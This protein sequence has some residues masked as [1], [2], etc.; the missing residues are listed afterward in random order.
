MTW[1]NPTQTNP[2]PR[3]AVEWASSHLASQA[4]VQTLLAATD[5]AEAEELVFA[6]RQ[7]VGPEGVPERFLVVRE[8]VD[9]G[10]RP[11]RFT[12]TTSVPMQ[13]MAECTETLPNKDQWHDDIHSRVFEALVGSVPDVDT[14][15]AANEIRRAQA[16]GRPMYDADSLTYFSTATYRFTLQP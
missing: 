11:Q 1:H 16:P 5:T 13:V 9:A 8:R 3:E 4:E 14:G 7:E 2:R 15:E 12:G 10:G 6:H